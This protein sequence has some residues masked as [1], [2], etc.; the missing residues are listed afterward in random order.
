MSDVQFITIQIAGISVS[1]AILFVISICIYCCINKNKNPS[2]TIDT[3]V[4]HEHVIV[5]P[6]PN[7]NQKK[8]R[9]SYYTNIV[10]VPNTKD[11]ETN[12]NYDKKDNCDEKYTNEE[13]TIAN[14]TNKL[15]MFDQTYIDYN[16]S[17]QEYAKIYSTIDKEFSPVTNIGIGNVF[18]YP[19]VP[20]G[21]NS[22][23]F[24]TNGTI[25]E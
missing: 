11:T 20:T 1:F 8:T 24:A 12:T 10:I 21:N 3:L 13:L 4:D 23:V 25:G 15:D 5:A 14:R 6:Q 18:L 17:D 16:L 19:F 22:V 2:Y 9:K 7:L